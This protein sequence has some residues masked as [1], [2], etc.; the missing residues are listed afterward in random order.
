MIQRPR[1]GRSVVLL[2]ECERGW[3]VHRRG[4]K[5]RP[6]QVA[7]R[8]ECAAPEMARARRRVRQEMLRALKGIAA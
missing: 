7:V 1:P 2:A 6:V 3:I 8:Y 5:G 4:P